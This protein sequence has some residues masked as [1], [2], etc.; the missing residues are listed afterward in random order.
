MLVRDILTMF[1]V[2][3]QAKGLDS[4]RFISDEDIAVYINQAI[5][6]KIRAVL[7]QNAQSKF[8]DKLTMQDNS[9]ASTNILRN[10]LTY[11]DV[12]LQ[13]DLFGSSSGNITL[14]NKAMFYTS[15]VANYKD[16]ITKCRVID[17]DKF[18]NHKGDYCSEVSWNSPIVTYIYNNDNLN[19][20]IEYQSKRFPTNKELVNVRVGY[21][22]H[23]NKFTVSNTSQDYKELPEYAYP[24]IVEIAVNSYFRSI[25]ATSQQVQQ[26]QEQTNQ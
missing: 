25:G 17:Y 21:V 23:P 3:G 8:T 13:G 9:I 22:R 6:N 14:Q 1:K 4:I 16:A 7:M 18:Y 12:P 11:V 5:V 15:F 20:L 2:N 19:V 26:Q 24:E 10:L